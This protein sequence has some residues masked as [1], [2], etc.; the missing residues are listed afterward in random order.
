MRSMWRMQGKGQP[1]TRTVACLLAS[2]MTLA[3]IPCAA[4]AQSRATN[5]FS[6]RPTDAWLTFDVLAAGRKLPGNVLGEHVWGG[7]AMFALELRPTSLVGLSV[8]AIGAST[9][10]LNFK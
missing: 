7:G 2:T 9:P 8:G 10:Q 5:P 3:V 4:G 6:E 1:L